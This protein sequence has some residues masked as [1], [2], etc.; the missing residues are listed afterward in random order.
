MIDVLNI[1]YVLDADHAGKFNTVRK[2]YSSLCNI[3]LTYRY[4]L[5]NTYF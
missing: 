5:R 4:F 2:L 1:I 3:I